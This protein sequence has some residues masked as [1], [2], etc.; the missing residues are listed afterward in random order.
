MSDQTREWKQEAQRAIL[1]AK[2]ITE[3]S[4]RERRDMSR[5]E[6]GEV[7]QLC[8]E[9]DELMDKAA[10][11]EKRSPY[12]WTGGLQERL[13]GIGTSDQVPPRPNPGTQ[14]AVGGGGF[15]I[16]RGGGAEQRSYDKLFTSGNGESRIAGTGDFTSFGEMA[17]AVVN[18]MA[19]ARLTRAMSTGTTS[20]GGAL[21]P[22]V[23]AKQVWDSSIENDVVMGRATVLPLRNGH[24]LRLPAWAIGDHSSSL[25]GGISCYWTAEGGSIS[26]SE[27]SARELVFEPKKCA[28]L[29]KISNELLIDV[30]GVGNEIEKAFARAL[31]WER[32]D[33]FLT[34]T[35]A[36]EPQGI[37]GAACTKTVDKEGGQS[38]STFVFQNAV[39]MLAALPPESYNRACWI[40][41][42][43]TIPELAT[44][45]AG[46]GLDGHYIKVQQD[47][48]NW[49]L[50]GLPIFFSEKVS[51]LGTAGDVVLAD[52]TQ[53][54]IVVSEELRI[55]SSMH[56]YFNSDESALRLVTRIDGMPA[57][58]EELTLKDGS[59]TQSPFVILQTRS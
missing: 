52:L 45:Y 22:E 36:G 59:S 26:T 32:D 6:L 46:T 13:D 47:D 12:H 5:A 55:D 48:G 53:Y 54:V 25:Y 1:R 18:R 41:H 9:H 20:D 24:K 31:S 28:A 37:I 51:S 50:L 10:A 57:W 42:P 19:D 21:V 3:R 8:K 29:C 44:I 38:A 17:H 39:N 23:Y 11:A 33:K 2:E 49:R 15:N 4:S 16:V 40:C 43:S 30:N 7:E 34:G 56:Y 27:P 35:G 14:R 58:D